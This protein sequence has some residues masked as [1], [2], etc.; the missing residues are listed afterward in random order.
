[1]MAE[2]QS[3]FWL[4]VL[5]KASWTNQHRQM[6][7]LIS[8]FPI[9]TT[10]EG[11]IATHKLFQRQKITMKRR[12]YSPIIL[13]I[14]F[15]QLLS[16]KQNSSKSFRENLTFCSCRFYSHLTL[17]S[18]KR[19]LFE[20]LCFGDITSSC[21]CDDASHQNQN[22]SHAFRPLVKYS[23]SVFRKQGLRINNWLIRQRAF[24]EIWST[25]QVWRA[26]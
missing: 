10:L 12:D 24:I 1:M 5:V 11:N 26:R 21:L 6:K 25:R 4:L 13:W 17:Y 3:T 16:M 23:V 18:V 2:R 15:V 14:T 20:I 19:F 22:P 7:P 9:S 8:V